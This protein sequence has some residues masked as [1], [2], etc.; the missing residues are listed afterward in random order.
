MEF[1]F[2]VAK[3]ATGQETTPASTADS[4]LDKLKTKKGGC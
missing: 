3:L 2:I 4:M 1:A